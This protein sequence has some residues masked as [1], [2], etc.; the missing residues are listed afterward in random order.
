MPDETARQGGMAFQVEKEVENH[1]EQE[2]AKKR[3]NR[4]RGEKGGREA[5]PTR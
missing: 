1:S 4:E 2:N 5:Q 3:G